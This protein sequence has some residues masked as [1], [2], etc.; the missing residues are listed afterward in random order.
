MVEV[1]SRSEFG[2]CVTF[3]GGDRVIARHAFA[4]VNDTDEP[5]AARFDFDV[6]LARARIERVLE[7]FLDYGCR[8]L[9]DFAGRDLIG[10]RVGH[11][12]DL[13]HRGSLEEN[14]SYRSIQEMNNWGHTS[15]ITVRSFAL[16]QERTYGG[17]YGGA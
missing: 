14:E 2:C 9:D 13:G 10:K 12:F 6:N 1:L 3:E 15:T 8:P 4:V 11:H 7:Q 5:L 17:R 16:S